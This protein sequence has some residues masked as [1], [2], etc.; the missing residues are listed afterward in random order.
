MA[1]KR[2]GKTRKQEKTS[3]RESGTPGGGQGRIDVVGHSGVYPVSSSEGA[4]GDAPVR[5]Q[6][7][8]GQGARGAAGYWDHG[9]SEAIPLSPE[10]EPEH[11]EWLPEKQ[12]EKA[13]DQGA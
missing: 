6:M 10:G 4:R 12:P 5:G 13:E 7:E 11:P 2:H 3:V 9:E 8:W 1:G